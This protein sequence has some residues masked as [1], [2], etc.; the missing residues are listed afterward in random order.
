MKQPKSTRLVSEVY[1]KLKQDNNTR[2]QILN[3]RPIYRKHRLRSL[4]LHRQADQS[5]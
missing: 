4:V 2:N 5:K 3:A 1:K